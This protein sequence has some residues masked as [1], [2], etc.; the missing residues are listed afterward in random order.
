[1]VQSS[2]RI[3]VKGGERLRAIEPH[4]SAL[5]DAQEKCLRILH[6]RVEQLHFLRARV[7]NFDLH[8]TV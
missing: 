7:R 1:M 4:A 8:G 3:V 5:D 6:A 2:G